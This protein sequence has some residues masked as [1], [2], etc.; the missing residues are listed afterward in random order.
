MELE[1][2]PRTPFNLDYTLTCG[3]AFRWKKV[4]AT[5]TGVVNETAIQI[6]QRG[7]RLFVHTVPDDVEDAL[8][9]THF[10][11]EDDLPYITSTI[12]RDAS[13]GTA[14]R[15]LQGLRIM[16]QDPWECL[17]SFICATFANIPRIQDMIQRLCQRFGRKI[18]LGDRQV[19]GFPRKEVLAA[20]SIQALLDCK[21]GYRARYVKQ[22]SQR[23]VQSNCSLEALR[24]T[25]Y[26]EAREA[27]LCLTGVG[28]KV[29]DCVLLFSL[30]KLEAFPVDIWIR[31]VL[32]T[33]YRCH[34][35]VP[36]LDQRCLTPRLYKM[37]NDFGRQYFGR[38]AGYAQ[39]YL[40]AEYSP[41]M[42][43]SGFDACCHVACKPV[44]ESLA[45]R[46]AA[47]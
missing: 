11:L 13:V 26:E 41:Q 45:A 24:K 32:Q 1:L 31:R 2:P 33:H 8:I 43:R 35:N 21:L 6:S 5:W 12:N 9:R 15:R 25:A 20:A 28:E 37:F 40:Y 4:G 29:A 10:R 39:E 46:E 3:Q 17:I 47:L 16:R 23:L 14:L 42:T 34:F 27:L 7:T 30:E 38:Y 36:N 19:Y 18:P 22:T 44:A